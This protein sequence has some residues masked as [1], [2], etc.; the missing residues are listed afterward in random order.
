MRYALAPHIHIACVDGDV[1]LLDAATDRYA[2]LPACDARE[3][4]SGYAARCWDQGP[5]VAELAAAGYLM[6]SDEPPGERRS[7]PTPCELD[8]HMLDGDVPALTVPDLTTTALAGVRTAWRLAAQRPMHWLRPRGAGTPRPDEAVALARRFTEAQL[9]LPFLARCLPRSL[10]LF[11]FLAR[12][13]C[14]AQLV[15]G[16]R[17]HPFEAHCWVQAGN[18]VLNDTL[19]RVRWYTPIAWS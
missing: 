18:I 7:L 14:P 16:V 4:R 19:S 9:H 3:I 15:F 6:P 10:A 8:L 11:D 5:L 12:R 1:V 17:T 2:C 13:A